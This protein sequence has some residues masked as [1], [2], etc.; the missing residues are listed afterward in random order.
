MTRAFEVEKLHGLQEM[1]EKEIK[2][3]GMQVVQGVTREVQR[4]M[5]EQICRCE[6]HEF[7]TQC[8]DSVVETVET[9]GMRETAAL[10]DSPPQVEAA[11]PGMVDNDVV[12]KST[13]AGDKAR[14]GHMDVE[15]EKLSAMS[16]SKDAAPKHAVE[17]APSTS[18]SSSDN[19][20]TP[21]MP[22]RQQS[23]RIDNVGTGIS[24]ILAGKRRYSSVRYSLK[25]SNSASRAGLSRQVSTAS[26]HP[27]VSEREGS[28]ELPR[29]S[30]EDDPEASD[31]FVSTD[32]LARQ[33][34]RASLQSVRTSLA[35]ELDEDIMA[36]YAV[37][38]ERSR[39]E[40]DRLKRY[41]TFEFSDAG[42]QYSRVE[43][44]WYILEHYTDHFMGV[45]LVLNAI[46]MG[47]IVD[48]K[49]GSE[50]NGA[51]VASA[52]ETVDWVF[53]IIFL[54][55]FA[56]RCF[57]DPRHFF[58][59]GEGW[60]W[61]VFDAIVLTLQLADQ[62]ILLIMGGSEQNKLFEGI[63][64]LRILRLGRLI[65]L[66]RMVRLIPELKS[67]VYL[68]LASMPS[69]F[70]TAL[71]ILLMVYTASI[72]FTE[73]ANDMAVNMSL[74][75]E[76]RAAIE[77]YWSSIGISVLTLYMAISGGGDWRDFIVVFLRQDS[78]GLHVVIFA[79]YVAFST[80]VML[81]L[82]TGVFVDGAQRIIR[83]EQD[84][85]IS[86]MAEKM[87]S[88]TDS[89][90]EIT[91]DAFVALE[92]TPAMSAYCAAVGITHDEAVG[93]FELLDTR[94]RRKLKISEFVKGSLRLRSTARTI[95][96]AQLA[97]SFQQSL[98]MLDKRTLATHKVITQLWSQTKALRRMQMR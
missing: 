91:W 81:N 75:V 58:S 15:Q 78:M 93:L 18:E 71:L 56:L 60:Q 38:K 1:L 51:S 34:R 29:A 89:T 61:N 47:I 28:A 8:S 24:S 72:F 73:I 49:Y 10:P 65:R 11:I 5:E 76:D 41:S 79:A 35:S 22:E 94:G 50:G 36:T 70:W 92:D 27:A 32:G 23:K 21:A 13:D 98:F 88:L 54:I 69:F 55:E 7:Q 40:R 57:S 80:L 25:T 95:D 33:G 6:C 30:S 3:F 62:S 90:T 45:V 67:M 43:Y 20:D 77:T 39:M 46:W 96:V 86:R 87:F 2:Q 26:G 97:D 19:D 52:A 66:V 48:V 82:V 85:E 83:Q 74:N 64:V 12:R 16:I 37:Q 84:E 53:C 42:K 4:F 9:T 68:I 44:F 31:S 59:F 17:E 63:A 14:A